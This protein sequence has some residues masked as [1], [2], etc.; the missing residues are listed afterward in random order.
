LLHPAPEQ[1]DLIGRADLGCRE[2]AEV[3]QVNID[4]ILTFRKWH[5]GGAFLG[6]LEW[7]PI[8]FY[9]LKKNKKKTTRSKIFC[10]G[11][12][13]RGG[14]L[15]FALENELSVRGQD[16][17]MVLVNKAKQPGIPLRDSPSRHI[18]QWY[19]Q[20]FLSQL[21]HLWSPRD[22]GGR[23]PLDVG[24]GDLLK[25]STKDV[26]LALW[27]GQII[28]LRILWRS[29]ICQVDLNFMVRVGLGDNLLG[30]LKRVTAPATTTPPTTKSQFS[31]HQ[32]P[33]PPGE[34]ER[35]KGGLTGCA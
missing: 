21:L 20:S 15:L 30:S 34:K 4:L 19:S 22:C 13:E 6:G 27:G 16:G 1:V 23:E 18:G 31:D 7:E 17:D 11:K 32:R 24:D 26:D 3:G 29:H 35:K 2:R 9:F 5:E 28:T 8:L 33:F 25:P 12:W 10:E 14:S